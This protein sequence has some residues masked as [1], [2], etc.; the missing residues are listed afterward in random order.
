MTLKD[1]S[2]SFFEQMHITSSQ[3]NVFNAYPAGIGP[4]PFSE[5][6]RTGGSITF[7]NPEH[8]YPQLIAYR[9]IEAGLAARI[10]SSDGSN[11]RDFDF[12][13]CANQRAA[14]YS[15]MTGSPANRPA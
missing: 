8:D 10:S 3:P 2:V 6:E 5:S 9:T 7:A 14:P 13:P 15:A 12:I 4:S 1:G 11:V